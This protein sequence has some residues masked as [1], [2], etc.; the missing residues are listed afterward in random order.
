M[1]ENLK[2]EKSLLSG[3]IQKTVTKTKKTSKAIGLNTS[4]PKIDVSAYSSNP[5]ARKKSKPARSSVLATTG[6]PKAS[7]S[8]II[9]YSKTPKRFTSSMYKPNNVLS[10]SVSAASDLKSKLN[11]ALKSARPLHDEIDEHTEITEERGGKTKNKIHVFKT[12]IEELK[13]QMDQLEIDYQNEKAKV[14]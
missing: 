6:T 8:K 2:K 5:G 13:K 11:P 12:E 10:R 1:V 7:K 14:A 9:P 3:E 4:V